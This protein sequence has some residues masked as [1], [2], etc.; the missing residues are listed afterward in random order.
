MADLPRETLADSPEHTVRDLRRELAADGDLARLI[1]DTAHDAFVAIDEDNRVIDWNRQAEAMFGWRREE[2]LGKPLAETIVPPQHR[3]AHLAGIVRFL[4]TGQGRVINERVQ[5]TALHRDGREFPVELTIRAIRRG[6]DGDGGGEGHGWVFA[7]FVQDITERVRA[8]EEIRR[9]SKQN[10]LILGFAGEGIYGLDADGV[11]AFANPAAVRLTGWELSEIVGKPQHDLIHHTKADGSPYPRGE[12]PIYAALKDGVVHHVSDEVFWRKDGTSFPVE[13]TS[14]PIRGED[15]AVTGA[16]V[17]FRDIT[18]R[19]QGERQ[20][21]EQRRELERSN[22]ELQQFAYVASH[23]LQ[24]PLRMVASYTQLLAKRYQ[25]KL[26]ADA[27]DFI[28]YAVDGARRMQTLINDLLAYSRVGTRGRPFEPTDCNQIVRLALANLKVAVEESGAAVDVGE[29][30]TVFADR[31]QLG[32]LFQNLLANAI[33]FRHADRPPRVSVTA[34]RVEDESAWRF[35]VADNGIGIAAEHFERIF[36][37]FQRLHTREQYAGTGIGL[38]VCRKIVER[39]GGR[40]WVE[41]E[42]D[43]GATFRFTIPDRAADASAEPSATAST[44]AP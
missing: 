18:E 39:H 31:T 14:T 19:R 3:A 21:E 43:R 40:M 34:E 1:I 7:A 13:Y 9:L 33:K 25:G 24:E 17:I 36:V 10:E 28:H 4:K 22:A 38:A 2:I 44:G 27:D 16:V 26:G 30:P 6:G 35:A 42:V 23:D 12:C 8:A 5:I 32:Q 15:G 29:L 11:T 37:I 41:S 20:V